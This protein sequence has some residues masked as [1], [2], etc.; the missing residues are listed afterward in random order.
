MTGQ[1]IDHTVESAKAL[2]PGDY[3]YS[4]KLH[5]I[6][7]TTIREKYMVVNPST[8]NKNPDKYWDQFI[9]AVNLNEHDNPTADSEAGYLFHPDE[10]VALI[11]T[12]A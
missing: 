12:E 11:A 8:K 6:D 4:K 2:K 7:G 9:P 3:F 10:M 1:Y 5:F